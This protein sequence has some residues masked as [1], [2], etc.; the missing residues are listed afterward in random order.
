VPTGITPAE[1]A[2]YAAVI[3]AVAVLCAALVTAV[4][5]QLIA[6]SAQRRRQ[7]DEVRHLAYARVTETFHHASRGWA[8][9]WWR[10]ACPGR[11][12]RYGTCRCTTP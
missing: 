3:G 2:L 1:G 10:H 9:R 6:A 12:P 11:R 7:W 4:V 8:S 5:A